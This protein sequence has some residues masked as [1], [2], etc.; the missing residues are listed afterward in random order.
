MILIANVDRH[1][2]IGK[3]NDMLFHNKDDLTRFRA[4]TLNNIVVMGRRT[5]ESLPGGKPL[6]DRENIVLTRGA[7]GGEGFYRAG[8]LEELFKLLRF[9]FAHDKKVYIIGGAQVYELLLPYCEKALITHTLALKPADSFFP[10][11]TRL[12]GWEREE[13]VEWH[14]DGETL[15]GYAVYRNMRTHLL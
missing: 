10:R 1:W 8:S 7:P 14:R 12:P 2:G 5:L 11:L 9:P 13:G 15:F 3:D 6:K 4:L